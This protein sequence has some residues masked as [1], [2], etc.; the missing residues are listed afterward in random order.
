[1]SKHLQRDLEALEQRLLELSAM[2][3]QMAH[4]ACHALRDMD[5]AAVAEM[6]RDEDVVNRREVGIEDE[7]LKILALH[8]PVAVDL[9]RVATVMKI[10]GDLERIADLAVN[11]GR[12][13]QSLARFPEFEMPDDL[14]KMAMIAISMVRDALAAF[15]NLD[16]DAARA[17][18]I[19]DDEVDDLNRD[20]IAGLRNLIAEHRGEIE[21]ALY[22]FS[23][24]RHVERIGDHAT[25]IA[26]DVIYLVEGEITRHRHD[27]SNI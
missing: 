24:S 12:R 16:A 5:L 20:V 22:F 18:C 23:A 15:V 27:E 9:R 25:N 3:E 1:M 26:E 6:M 8:Q 14:D 11:I 7:C 10:N 4:R 13:T 19:R 17:V 21:P 2:V